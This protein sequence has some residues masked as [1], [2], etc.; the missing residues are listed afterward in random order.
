MRDQLYINGQWVSPDLGG[1]LEVVDPATEQVFHRI[2]AGTEE[3][4]DHAVRA[5]RRAFDNGWSQTTGAER[6]QWLDGPGRRTGK[7]PV[8]RW[9]NW[10]C[11]TTASRCPKRSGTSAMRSAVSATTPAWPGNWT[12]R[13]SHWPADARFRCRIRHEPIGVAGQ[14]IPWNYPLLMAAWKVPQPGGRRHGG[15][16]TV[17]TD[18]IDSAGAGRRR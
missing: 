8:R 3:D 1:Y 18:A 13:T 10:R 9:R 5:A 17:R 16:E 11:A 4:V 14:I 6:A 2:A 15:V 7:R 12:N